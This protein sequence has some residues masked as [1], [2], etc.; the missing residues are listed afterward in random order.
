MFVGRIH[1]FKSR[2]GGERV[3]RR[4]VGRTASGASIYEDPGVEFFPIDIHGRDLSR[5]VLRNEI[6]QY[7]SFQF[8]KSRRQG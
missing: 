5:F 7:I 2:C 6:G 3:P 1:E 4:F 8:E